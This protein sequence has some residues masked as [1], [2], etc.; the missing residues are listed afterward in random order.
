[1]KYSTNISALQPKLSTLEMPGGIHLSPEPGG[2][3]SRSTDLTLSSLL[4]I[5]K[6]FCLRFNVRSRQ[7]YN[8][9]RE[10][11]LRHPS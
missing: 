4:N 3:R 8:P 11:P 10:S 9:G 5:R 1:M 2:Q 6:A 7:F